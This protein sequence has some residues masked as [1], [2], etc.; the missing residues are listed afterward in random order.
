MLTVILDFSK[1]ELATGSDDRSVKIW[2]V[3]PLEAMRE[4][5]DYLA[6]QAY[7]QQELERRRQVYNPQVVHQ[8]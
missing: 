5:R 4:V 2:R 7:R 8:S 3:L 6:D 1:D